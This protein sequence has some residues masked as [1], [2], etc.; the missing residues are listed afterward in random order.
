MRN[1]ISFLSN[2]IFTVFDT[3]FNPEV[4]FLE[5]FEKRVKDHFIKSVQTP[6]LYV[7]TDN[8]TDLVVCRPSKLLVDMET[9]LTIA[10][11]LSDFGNLC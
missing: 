9:F 4:Y 2:G 11:E 5:E 8:A 7:P 6:D 3:K 1:L 10:M